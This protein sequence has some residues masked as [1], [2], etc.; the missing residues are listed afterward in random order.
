MNN[1]RPVRSDTERMASNI[2]S[3]ITEEFLVCQIC[4]EDYDRPKILPCLHT[5]CQGCLEKLPAGK[6]T[7]GPGRI[8]CPT[9]RQTATLPKDGVRALKDNFLVT[10]LSDVMKQTSDSAQEGLGEARCTTCE[11]DVYA[12]SYC[13]DCPDYLCQTCA[14]SHCRPKPTRSHRV[15]TL[16]DL[17]SGKVLVSA[18]TGEPSKCSI[19]KEVH[20]FYCETC[21]QVI[22][23]HCVVT[24][25]KEHR[26]VEVEE[27]AGKEKCVM[28]GL[29]RGV[30][31]GA[32]LHDIWLHEL[33]ECGEKW[34]SQVEKMTKD[35]AGQADAIIGTVQRLRDQRLAQVRSL[36]EARQKQLA[37]A[38]NT[39][40]TR[41]TQ[42]RNTIQFVSHLLVNGNPVELLNVAEGVKEELL[43]QSDKNV[44]THLSSTKSFKELS[45]SP[46][47]LGLEEEIAKLLGDLKQKDV[48]VEVPPVAG[49]QIRANASLSHCKEVKLYKAIGKAGKEAGEF[50]SPLC[51]AI[52]GGQDVVATDY[53]NKCLQVVDK[54]GGFKRKIDLGFQ[55]ECVT[56]LDSGELL[57]TGDGPKV[58]V[59]N[60]EGRGERVIHVRNVAEKDTVGG[61]IAVDGLGR[62]VVTVGWQVFVLLPNG[63]PV[64]EF[65]DRDFG[66]IL[67]VATDSRNHVIVSDMRNNNVKVFDPDYGILFKFGKHGSGDGQ[68]DHP[69]GLYVDGDDNIIVCDSHNHRVSQFDRDG[70]FVR[71]LLTREDGLHYPW[72]LTLMHDG[73]MV[74][75][76]MDS[77]NG[78]MKLFSLK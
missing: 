10:K 49:L 34:E 26:Y 54:E 70:L 64:C 46:A 71:H 75:C 27:A 68:L 19:H 39:A 15:V 48:D 42:A 77:K 33:R 43:K 69:M 8:S 72:G 17:K 31:R 37:S 66:Y 76:D 25:H 60:S 14:T 65:G 50:D 30:K 41:L 16:K 36:H 29:L 78:R 47:S 13:V 56:A 35:I 32:I 22:C 1:R 7:K 57:V 40:D 24:T 28:E 21:R 44:R 53:R 74:V 61:G 5:F 11:A 2:L 9:C 67:R 73:K 62:I 52:T 63:T 38:T 23:L 58:H 3:H 18:R 20:K 45:Y 12:T 4:L 6:A 51:I 55:P 59:M